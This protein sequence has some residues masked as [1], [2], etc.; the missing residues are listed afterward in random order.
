VRNGITVLVEDVEENVD[1]AI[2]PILNKLQAKSDA[3][4]MQIKLGDSMVDY[5]ENF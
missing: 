3:G 5:D 2:D 4:I 1:P